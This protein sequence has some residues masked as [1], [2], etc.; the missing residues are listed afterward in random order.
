M[1]DAVTKVV[2]T[3]KNGARET[4]LE[5]YVDGKKVGSLTLRDDNN[6]GRGQ[7]NE[8][9]RAV[10]DSVFSKDDIEKNLLNN[11]QQVGK[12]KV[13]SAFDAQI[14][15]GN[16][17][18]NAGKDP[19][20]TTFTL[21]SLASLV[22]PELTATPANNT[23]FGGSIMSN[24]QSGCNSGGC[25]AAPFPAFPPLDV[26]P[27]MG[28][29]GFGFGGFGFGG[30][31][32]GGGLGGLGFGIGRLIGGLFNFTERTVDRATDGLFGFKIF[33]SGEGSNCQPS[34]NDRTA[35]AC[36]SPRVTL[37]AP[38]APAAEAT[39]AAPVT[40]EAPKAP[41]A[42]APAPVTPV[43]A[44]APTPKRKGLSNEAKLKKAQDDLAELECLQAKLKAGTIDCDK[45]A[46]V[47]EQVTKAHFDK[48]Y[49]QIG[50]LS[51]QLGK[52]FEKK[53]SCAD[54]HC[55]PEGPKTGPDAVPPTKT[56]SKYA[57]KEDWITKEKLPNAQAQ[58]DKIKGLI[59]DI[60][61]KYGIAVASNIGSY[62]TTHEVKLPEDKQKI[63]DE[64]NTS[65]SK[66]Q[67]EVNKYKE[68]LQQVQYAK[69]NKQ[70]ALDEIETLKKSRE[71]V[72]NR[73]EVDE[74]IKTLYDQVY[75]YSQQIS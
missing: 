68:K 23:P 28:F 33:G 51:Q 65:L 44:G 48:L 18:I 52:P 26:S 59:A 63:V 12:N 49:S 55:K 4:S 31:G 6:D 2:T 64:L 71:F 7:S 30:C 14:N 74:K 75:G 10:G 5:K 57:D 9:L 11:Y 1:T 47:K 72:T 24:Y 66:A 69:Q 41:E 42:A 50:W 70:H 13:D 8:I 15:D 61:N 73:A 25:Y 46:K 19:K 67:A 45:I 34:C 56:A 36:D 3:V 40:P 22:K 32:F 17:Q 27:D 60:N 38:E 62:A 21:G 37:R 35:S 39:P 58:V 53:A 20:G 43:A 29:G 16:V 54:G